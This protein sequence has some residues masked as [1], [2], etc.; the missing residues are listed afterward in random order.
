MNPLVYKQTSVLGL[1]AIQAFSFHDKDDMYI[2]FQ[3]FAGVSFS[4]RSAL[5]LPRL[6]A[7]VRLQARVL[8][9]VISS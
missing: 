8:S 7:C 4:G 6:R 9:M 3:F 2:S 1:Q 5:S